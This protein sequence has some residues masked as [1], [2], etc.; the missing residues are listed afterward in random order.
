VVAAAKRLETAL[1]VDLEPYGDMAYL[2]T[3]GNQ[4]VPFVEPSARTLSEKLHLML[5]AE[6][7]QIDSALAR[8]LP[9][10]NALLAKVG[11]AAI[12]P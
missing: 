5:Q 10:A 8:D 7:A 12:T 4:V 3:K 9:P 6:V 2:Q 11:K 1:N